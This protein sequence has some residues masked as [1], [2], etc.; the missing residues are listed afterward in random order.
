MKFWVSNLKKYD[1]IRENA[2]KE[3]YDQI[4]RNELLE[5]SKMNSKNS[6]A[7]QKKQTTLRS[8]LRASGFKPETA[9]DSTEK[10]TEK[11][12]VKV[13]KPKGSR[14]RHQGNAKTFKRKTKRSW[15]V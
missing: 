9:E 4:R 14:S 13:E 15:R 1:K 2:K 10:P 8:A 5:K 12:G 6:K 3:E 11:E 7:K